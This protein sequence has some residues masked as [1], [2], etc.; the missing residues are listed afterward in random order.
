MLHVYLLLLW[1]CGV[2]NICIFLICDSVLS[3]GHKS[4]FQCHRIAITRMLISNLPLSVFSARYNQTSMYIF[5]NC[6]HNH[7]GGKK[8]FGLLSAGVG[9]PNSTTLT[10]SAMN[11]NDCH[12]YNSAAN[13]YTRFSHTLNHRCNYLW[14]SSQAA[15]INQFQCPCV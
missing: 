8:S 2:L 1:L 11:R 6:S 14:S 7:P 10:M 4:G 12:A 15:M 13:I 5:G 3:C 9:S